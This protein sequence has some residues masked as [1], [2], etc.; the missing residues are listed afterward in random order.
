MS[1]PRL[2]RLLGLTTVTALTLTLAA[3]GEEE[4]PD[5]ADASADRTAAL[6]EGGELLIW[7]WEPTLEGVVEQFA[8]DYPEVEVELV[9]VGTGNDAYTALQNAISAGSG[10]PD[11]VQVEYYAIPQFALSEGIAD[12]TELGAAELDGTFSTGPWSSVTAGTEAIY[13]L[14][15][16]SGPMAMFYNA[17]VFDEHDLEVPVT[18]AEFAEAG[19]ALQEADP[20]AYITNDTGDAGFA[21]SLI[22]QAGGRPFTGTGEDVT[23][24]LADEGS[25]TY[26]ELWTQ[27]TQ[28]DLLAPIPSWSDEWYQ[29][30]GDGTIA[31]LVT[32]AWMPANLESGVPDAAG[33]WR[34]A[35]M[36]QWEEGAG[37]TAENGGSGLSIPEASEN[38]DLAYA[39]MEYAT[40]GEGVQIRL[41]GGAFPAT[42]A[43]LESP[44][45]LAREWDYFGG[46]AINEVLSESAAQVDPDWQYL[47]FQVYANS[48]FNDSLGASYTGDQSISDGLAAWQDALIDYGTQQGFTVGR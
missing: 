12:L 35:P 17:D 5:P 27:L 10:V 37:V 18:W 42:V 39:F 36:P 15:M 8:A 29:A 34:V 13:G 41:D 48:V 45:F 7:A 31:T 22:W 47:P 38:A 3:C 6:E 2:T 4:A 26:A 11:V 32:G 14:P 23:I 25:A 30:L 9:N 28:E 44:E 20:D 46:Q 21:T 16:D 19:Q 1:R 40:A 33:A 24:D 43:D